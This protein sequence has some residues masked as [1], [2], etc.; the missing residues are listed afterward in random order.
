MDTAR[1]DS[2]ARAVGRRGFI[3]AALALAGLEPWTALAEVGV[4]G[5][6]GTC[7][8]TTTG[9]PGASETIS[10]APGIAS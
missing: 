4:D 5:A 3:A 8:L 7:L 1:F 9:G 10:V 6:P 2:L